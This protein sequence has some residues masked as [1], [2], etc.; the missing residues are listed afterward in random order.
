MPDSPVS[1]RDADDLILFAQVI[2]A[3]S[4]SEAALRVDVPKSTLSRRLSALE[5]RLGQRLINRT[6]RRLTITE[7]GQRMLE[8]AQRLHEEV[9]IAVALAHQ[10]QA[11]PQGLLRVSLPPDLAQID[12]TSMLIAYA[13]QYPLVR[14]ELDLS[15]RRVDLVAE[16]FDVAIRIAD[17]LP[18]DTTLVARKLGD[19]AVHLY[20]SPAY[21]K[22]FGKPQRPEDLLSHACLRLIS[23]SGEALPWRL[24]RSDQHWSGLPTGPV[25]SNSPSMQRTLA[26]HGMGIVALAEPLVLAQLAGGQLQRVLPAWA[27][28]SV[29]VWCVTP[30]RRLLPARTTA[31]IDMLKAAM[32]VR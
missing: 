11:Q 9:Q 14:I 5:T 29:T 1:G 27:L 13:A 4:F 22:Q 21:L 32:R 2:E 23:A 28:P 16:R 30:G 10:E 7:F 17:R 26:T 12:L 25:S 19:M 8:H 18:D 15:P 6:T 3:G 20:A 24:S 31:F